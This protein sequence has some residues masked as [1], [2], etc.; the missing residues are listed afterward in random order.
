MQVLC[1]LTHKNISTDT[2]K[3]ITSIFP[4]QAELLCSARTNYH[5]FLLCIFPIQKM[6]VFSH[7]R[8]IITHTKRITIHFP[9]TKRC[10]V[11][12]TQIAMKI[13]MIHTKKLLCS[14]HATKNLLCILH[15]KNVT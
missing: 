15:T 4:I 2:R 14:A 3:K 11:I 13:T 12:H 8:I 9:H 7:T 5:T 10:Y 1:V 6:L